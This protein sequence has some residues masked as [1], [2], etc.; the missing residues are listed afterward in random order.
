MDI[1]KFI[2]ALDGCKYG[3]NKTNIT[4]VLKEI[5]EALDLQTNLEWRAHCMVEDA[6]HCNEYLTLD[7]DSQLRAD[8]RKLKEYPADKITPDL[9]R[10]AINAPAP[11]TIAM[12]KQTKKIRDKITNELL[13]EKAIQINSYSKRYTVDYRWFSLWD[14]KGPTIMDIL[15]P[16]TARELFDKLSITDGAYNIDEI[17]RNLRKAKICKPVQ[18][19]LDT[20]ETRKK[21]YITELEKINKVNNKY[22]QMLALPLSDNEEE[23]DAFISYLRISGLINGFGYNSIYISMTE[24]GKYH[25]VHEYVKALLLCYYNS[26]KLEGE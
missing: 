15:Q 17:I 18:D 20:I 1:K 11:L 2:Y 13:C 25:S 8:G 14:T 26:T 4:T 7:E 6:R 21:L 23:N 16:K 9:I 24:D 3:I 12:I 22:T 10:I 19:V 5:T